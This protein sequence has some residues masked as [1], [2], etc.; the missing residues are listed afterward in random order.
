[1]SK[2]A[3]F[4]LA[5]TESHEGLGR[6]F[7]AL[8]A[9]KELKEGGDDV[10][11]IFDGAGT[12]WPGVLSNPEHKAHAI[13]DAVRDRVAGAC[14]FCAGAFGVSEQARAC[15]TPLLTEYEG[16]PSVKKLIKDGYQLL[17]Y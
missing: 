3:I 13:Y 6:V 17:S 2:V 11:L 5:D 14:S 9:V 8:E 7:N 1:M 12:K 4:V 10:R 16:H 15:G